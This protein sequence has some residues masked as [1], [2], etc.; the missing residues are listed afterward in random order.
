MN[1][2]TY[3]YRYVQYFVGDQHGDLSRAVAAYGTITFSAGTAG[4]YSIV[5]AMEQDSN[6]LSPVP[7]SLSTDVSFNYA[8]GASGFGFLCNPLSSGD[9]IWGLVW[10][11]GVFVGSTTET[12]QPFNDLFIAAPASTYTS[13]GI[14]FGRLYELSGRIREGYSSRR[15]SNSAGRRWGYRSRKHP[16]VYGDQQQRYRCHRTGLVRL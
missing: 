1:G 9:S 16:D 11:S 5:T 14:V 8:I 2:Q 13:A 7:Q 3:N 15:L 4:T 12:K 6:S 10:Q